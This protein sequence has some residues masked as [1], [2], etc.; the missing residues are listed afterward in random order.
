MACLHLKATNKSNALA[1]KLTII[2][3]FMKYSSDTDVFYV[4]YVVKSDLRLFTRFMYV[5]L[6]FLLHLFI[7]CKVVVFND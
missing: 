2:A 4:H 7:V 5:S 3:N 1:F 6:V